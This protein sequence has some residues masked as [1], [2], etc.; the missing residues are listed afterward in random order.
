VA[1]AA[2]AHLRSAGQAL[3]HLDAGLR[4]SRGCRP[5][6]F[7]LLPVRR[8]GVGSVSGSESESQSGTL[9]WPTASARSLTHE[10]P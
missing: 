10:D 2:N 9:G 6:G 1:R 5:A 8:P 3:R 7:R 4:Q